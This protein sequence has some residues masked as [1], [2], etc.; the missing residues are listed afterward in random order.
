VGPAAYEKLKYPLVDGSVFFDDA[1]S[2]RLVYNYFS[3]RVSS[4]FFS[5]IRGG[6]SY[7]P[8]PAAPLVYRGSVPLFSI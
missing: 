1:G 4:A 6:K 2:G 5:T 3:T 7:S 8:Y